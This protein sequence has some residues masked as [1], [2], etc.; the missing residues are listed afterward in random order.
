[1]LGGEALEVGAVQLSREQF[2]TEG[3]K[4][5]KGQGGGSQSKFK[6]SIYW[7]TVTVYCVH[8]AIHGQPLVPA[9]CG[10]GDNVAI[11]LSTRPGWLV[12]LGREDRRHSAA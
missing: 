7:F 11:I 2:Q 5:L 9:V 4:W 6:P 12:T 3:S 1:M 10:C 8:D